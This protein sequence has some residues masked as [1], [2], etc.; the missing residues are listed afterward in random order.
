MFDRSRAARWIAAAA[1]AAAAAAAA[2]PS[3]EDLLKMADRP[4]EAFGEAVVS[5]RVSITDNGATT[6]PAEFDLYKKGDDKGLV[7]FTAGRQKGRKILTVGDD[8]W[9]IVPGSSR[10]IPVSLNQRLIGG[11]SVGDVARLDFSREFDAALEPRPEEVG[12]LVCDVLDLT[13]RTGASTYGSGK[14]WIDRKEHLPRRALLNLAS[15]KPSKDVLF[16]RF[17]REEGRTVLRSMTVRDLLAPGHPETRLEYFRY[18][19]AQLPDSIFTPNGAL[20]F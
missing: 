19:K 11:A 3:A 14:L 13:A 18:R 9:L 12:G 1:L 10:A 15:G 6:H 7:V 5:V 20:R 16:D 4:R 2:A 8:F 17:D